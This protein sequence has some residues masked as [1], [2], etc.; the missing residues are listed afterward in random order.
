MQVLDACLGRGI[1]VAGYVGGGYS[2]DLSV[3][4]RRHA[5]L[6]T[7]AVQLWADHRLSA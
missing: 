7:A 3:L 1:P 4:A 5:L 6:H 2:P